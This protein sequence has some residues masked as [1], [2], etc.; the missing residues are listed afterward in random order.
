MVVGSRIVFRAKD[1]K[2]LMMEIHTTRAITKK[3][4][5]M[6]QGPSRNQT[7]PIRREIGQMIIWGALFLED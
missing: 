1:V 3:V 7:G 6:V 4:K 5:N 2:F